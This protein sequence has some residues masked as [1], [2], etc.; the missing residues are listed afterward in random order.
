MTIIGVDIGQA[1]DYTA[2]A[3]L[4]PA[5]VGL[6][7]E[8]HCIWIER[9]PL[10]T[11]YIEVI[12]R[13]DRHRQ[14]VGGGSMIVIDATGVGR[15][16][17]EQAR[18]EIKGTQIH[19]LTITGGQAGHGWNVPKRALITN[20]QIMLQTKTL[21]IA[22]G[23]VFTSTI[24]DELIAYQVRVSTSGHESYE[25]WRES[26]H[27]DLVLALSIAGWAAVKY[28]PIRPAAAAPC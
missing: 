16:I 27:D 5:M 3:L 17:V 20:L 28:W 22:A 25:P 4:R 14:K 15:P 7:R 8:Y 24:E 23:M 10:G 21:K 9:L 19:G 13:V 1:Q 11:S 12:R 2:I 26:E 6:V 18:R